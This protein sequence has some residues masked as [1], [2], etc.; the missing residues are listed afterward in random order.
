MAFFRLVSGSIEYGVAGV[1]GVDGVDV[2]DVVDIVDVVERI[3]L[4]VLLIWFES[5][6][7]LKQSVCKKWFTR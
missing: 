2:V 4:K 1:D 5:T 7:K 6:Q 3:L